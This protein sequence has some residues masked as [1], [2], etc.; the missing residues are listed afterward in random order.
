MS[1]KVKHPNRR[2]SIAPMMG[3]TDRHDRYFMRLITPNALLYTVMITTGALVY[4]KKFEVLEFS[5]EE[6]P[7]ALQL[8][9]SDPADLAASAKW[10]ENYGYDEINLN[11]GCPSDR[12][13]R[14][15]FGACLMAEP[16][17]VADCI[18]AMKQVVSIPV[19]VKTR[20]G[21]DDNDS[22]DFVRDFVGTVAD[23]GCD[24]F[25]IH[26]RKAWLNGLSPA[27]NR[28]IPPLK[29]ET[30]YQLKKDF[31]Q[32]EIILNGGLTTV[33]AVQDA[34]K[35]LDGVMIGRE[36][37]SNPYFMA[38]IEGAVFGTENIPSRHEVIERLIP[39]IEAH[40]KSG[41]PL[42]DITRHILGLFQG[43]PNARK[44]RRILSEEAYKDGA[45]LDV[46]RMALD[47]LATPLESKTF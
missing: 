19:T 41:E 12:V 14:G 6:H 21:I 2:V 37:Y 15:K 38:D 30:A 23:K 35:N 16:A 32:L 13:Q 31:P 1:D 9:G 20:I 24:T 33:D 26:A 40:L 29:Y 18:D 4:G 7:V 34:L 43:L 3:W 36:A 47:S 11:C 45:G 10:G 27:E 25:I 42:K 28:T 44:W 17:L 5:P 46:V 39:Y 22:Y 8:G